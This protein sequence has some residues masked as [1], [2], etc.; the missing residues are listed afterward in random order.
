MAQ[1]NLDRYVFTYCWKCCDL[2]RAREYVENFCLMLE[3]E[4]CHSAW[5]VKEAH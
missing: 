5:Q 3:C 2:T 1:L 4:T